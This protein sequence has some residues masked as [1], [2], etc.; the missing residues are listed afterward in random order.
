MCEAAQAEQIDARNIDEA[1]VE[2][3][4]A[5]AHSS[6]ELALVLQFCDES[7]LGS[8]PPWQIRNS[9]FIHLGSLRR[10]T[11]ARLHSAL[12]EF[13]SLHQRHGT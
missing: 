5:E 10:L 11:P 8:L 3:L 7:L 1:A 2:R 6:L 4:L 13:D 9:H 12:L